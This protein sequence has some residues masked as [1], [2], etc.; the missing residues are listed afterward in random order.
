MRELIIAENA[1]KH[2]LLPT[3]IEHAWSNFAAMQFRGSPNEGEIVCIGFDAKG[4]AVEMIAAERSFGVIIF[5]AMMPPTEKVIRELG[6]E[7]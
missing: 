1:L 6:L 5:H 4:R 2:G 3:D 7:S